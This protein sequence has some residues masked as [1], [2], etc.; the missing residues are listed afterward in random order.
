MNRKYSNGLGYYRG[1]LD[2]Y[3]WFL[4]ECFLRRVSSDTIM[5]KF[6]RSPS[7]ITILVLLSP[8]ID[9]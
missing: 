4:S 9:Y 2:A 1:H 7:K 6:Y 5:I 3:I 8:C